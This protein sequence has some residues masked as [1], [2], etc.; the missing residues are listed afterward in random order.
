MSIPTTATATEAFLG[1]TFLF[2]VGERNWDGIVMAKA[3][4]AEHGKIV[5]S[6]TLARKSTRAGAQERLKE[7][8]VAWV[9]SAGNARLVDEH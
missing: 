3:E 5:C 7:E 2:Y 8:C 9:T 6:F 4:V 1:W